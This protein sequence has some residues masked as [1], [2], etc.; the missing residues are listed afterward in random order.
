MKNAIGINL[1]SHPYQIKKK[2]NKWKKKK[3]HNKWRKKKPKK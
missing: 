1:L 2:K 3:T